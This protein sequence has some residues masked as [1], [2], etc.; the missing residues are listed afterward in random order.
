MDGAARNFLKN[1][2]KLIFESLTA[3]NHYLAE[4]VLI[5]LLIAG[6][7]NESLAEVLDPKPDGDAGENDRLWQNIIGRYM[8]EVN[9]LLPWFT[10]RHRDLPIPDT[11]VREIRQGIRYRP[12]PAALLGAVHEIALDRPVPVTKKGSGAMVRKKQG[13]YYTPPEIVN[14]MVE[15]TMG[16]I[17]SEYRL[18]MQQAVRR[19]SSSEITALLEDLAEFRVLDPACGSAAFLTAVMRELIAFYAELPACIGV[20]PAA[21]AIAHLY[22]TDSDARAVDLTIIGLALSY[23]SYSEAVESKKLL[24][25]NIRLGDALT[26]KWR[27][28]FAE[29]FQGYNPGFSLVIGN[30]PYI[31]NKL[32]PLPLKKYI[33]QHYRTV[34]GQY[35]II[36]P[37]IEKGLEI[38]ND[39]GRL[40]FIISNKYLAADY[41]RKLRS[42]LLTRHNLHQLIDL[43]EMKVFADAAVY[44]VIQVIEKGRKNMAGQVAVR[45]VTNLQQLAHVKNSCIIP[46]S[47]YH[48]LDDMIITPKINQATWPVL[49]TISR[50]PGRLPVQKI[51]CGIAKTGFAKLVIDAQSYDRLADK[52][53]TNYRKFLNSGCIDK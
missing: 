46:E 45:E 4:D 49:E 48:N 29:V 26:I 13:S 42:E 35:D 40:C 52:Y 14:Y 17:L 10:D 18:K 24:Q 36:V 28:E 15:L 20:N 6:K 11:V 30:P 5:F 9:Q 33:N 21:G 32:L 47:F 31:S 3:D 37:F 27:Q 41:G 22:G 25:K 1:S 8:G 39:G 51:L 19:E 50:I 53:K 34:D 12:N 44:P 38:L 2:Y 23:G 16:Q 7:I 43:S